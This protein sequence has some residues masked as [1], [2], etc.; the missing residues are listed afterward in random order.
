ALIGAVLA[1]DCYTDIR[2]RDA[3]SSAVNGTYIYQGK[4]GGRPQWCTSGSCAQSVEWKNGQW[5]IVSGG[6]DMYYGCSCLLPKAAGWT[7]GPGGTAPAPRLDGGSKCRETPVFT[8]VPAGTAGILDRGWPEGE[9]APIVGELPVAALYE[10]GEIITGCVEIL[11]PGGD[12]ELREQVELV[13]WQVVSIGEDFDEKKVLDVRLFRYGSARE[14][15][16][17]SLPTYVLIN[18][19]E[20]TPGYYDL[21]LN[22]PNETFDEMRIQLVEPPPEAET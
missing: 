21:R 10:I 2:V 1:G 7:I 6:Q 14:A 8:I 17:F 15:Y 5:T 19:Y 20:W 3:G 18:G 4:K 13:V 22:Y 9:V 12:P 16:C 11:D